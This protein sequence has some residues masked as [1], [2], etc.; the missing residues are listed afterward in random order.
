MSC[1]GNRASTP[2]VCDGRASH[3]LCHPSPA[4]E[5]IAACFVRI[6]LLYLENGGQVEY[7]QAMAGHESPRT[8]KLYD[9][10]DDSVSLDEVEKIT[11]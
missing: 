4:D 1:L 9:R 6:H 7:A 11:I 2:P 10:R 3:E 8:T 5:S